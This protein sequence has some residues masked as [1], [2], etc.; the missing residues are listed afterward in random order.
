MKQTTTITTKIVLWMI[1]LL[2]AAQ[3]VLSL[4][5]RPA[6]TELLSE[7][8]MLDGKIDYS[9]VFWVVNNDG[10]PFE[11]NI[12]V[13]G[14]MGKYA[15]IKEEKLIF[16]N[17]DDA[18]AVEFE[19]H[20]S[21]PAEIPPGL[22]IANIVVEEDLGSS[23]SSSGKGISSKIVLKHKIIIQGPYPDKYI[24]TK[25]N[26]HES[27]EAIQ[28]V[29]EVENLGKKDIG[30]VQTIFYVNDKEQQKHELETETASLGTTENR[31]L[32][33]IVSKELFDEGE[34]EVSAITTY[35]DQK[36]EMVK[37]LVIGKP[38]IDITYFDKYF[39]ANIINLYTLELLNKWNQKIENVY[40]DVDVKK[41]NVK[42]DHFRTKSVDIN[43][44]MRKKINDYFDARGKTEGKYTFDMAVNFWN[45]YKMDTR[46]FQVELLAEGETV[47]K[48]ESPENNG[49][50]NL[51]GEA[52]GPDN[53]SSSSLLW[54][55]VGIVILTLLSMYVLWKYKHRDEYE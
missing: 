24:S 28:L 20:I 35:D 39:T 17:D 9:G 30:Q 55:G 37:K 40:V 13:D 26:F 31:L 53:K 34:F 10:L 32:S 47:E 1:I 33:A 44:M 50:G 36:V 48:E 4:G 18:K 27:E 8:I 43:G 42:I 49:A 19:V 2:V 15:T 3:L 16:R 38:E 46:T 11:V 21:N 14:E 25:L 41:D 45:T 23:G 54:V 51:A 7:K 22:S 12:Y 52:S 6:K 5:I 29:S